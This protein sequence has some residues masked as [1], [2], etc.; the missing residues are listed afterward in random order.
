MEFEET[1]DTED[2]LAFPELFKGIPD[3]FNNCIKLEQFVFAKINKIRLLKKHSFY[4]SECLL[5]FVLL[6]FYKFKGKHFSRRFRSLLAKTVY[7]GVLTFSIKSASTSQSEVKKI[8][9]F[10][11]LATCQ[12]KQQQKREEKHGASA[13]VVSEVEQMIIRNDM[14]GAIAG[15]LK[16]DLWGLAFII[17]H[18]LSSSVVKSLIKEYTEKS[19]EQDNIISKISN[20][21]ANNFEPLF[22]TANSEIFTRQ[23]IVALLLSSSTSWFKVLAKLGEKVE[24]AANNIFLAHVCFVLSSVPFNTSTRRSFLLL[25]ES[26]QSRAS[27]FEVSADIEAVLRTEIYIQGCILGSK[28]KQDQIENSSDFSHGFS[29][30][31]V[32]RM[33]NSFNS[34]EGQL[35]HTQKMTMR[36]R[37]ETRIQRE[38]AKRR[39]FLL[40]QFNR[41]SLVRRLLEI[42]T[43]DQ[44]LR[45][46]LSCVHQSMDIDSS[47][48]DNVEYSSADF[49]SNLLDQITAIEQLFSPEKLSELK[50]HQDFQKLRKILTGTDTSPSR[51]RS[52]NYMTKA[53]SPLRL[54]HF[55]STDQNPPK[56]TSPGFI[57]EPKV[58][59]VPAKPLPNLD[60]DSVA[61][62]NP[63][64][65]SEK[66]SQIPQPESTPKNT[67]ENQPNGKSEF[68]ATPFA[69]NKVTKKTRKPVTRRRRSFSKQ[70]RKYN[71]LNGPIDP[72]FTKS[73]PAMPPAPVPKQHSFTEGQTNPRPAPK[74]DTAKANPKAKLPA[75]S[76][77]S[78]FKNKILHSMV[79][80]SE[81]AVKVSE[82]LGKDLDAYYDDTLKRWVFPGEESREQNEP[83][84]AGPPKAL[85]TQPKQK[86]QVKRVGGR[87]Y[88]N[89]FDVI[90]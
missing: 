46:V 81:N 43:E 55:S 4:T 62:Q 31:G 11:N 24:L 32:S 79:P 39:T 23:S 61:T 49:R 40:Y 7:S 38:K 3:Y 82:G 48:F 14:K 54:N 65:K 30:G 56:S 64:F 66:V 75:D 27:F 29:D 28:S 6:Q 47:L 59:V 33:S 53:G 36:N 41:F 15:C 22:R 89:S 57:A 84:N 85:P 73:T 74:A 35:A 45:Y 71:S 25:G 37:M 19:M 67:V 88:I 50:K 76:F 77:L 26:N 69:M 44:A 78:R 20:I 12:S 21:S 9:L 5:W 63:E 34:I 90:K 52:P 87:A 51:E 42:G 68:V 13:A 8:A 72:V 1:N 2:L 86:R 10:S 17:A 80:V 58:G 18:Q 60:F 70:G 83:Q 16:Y